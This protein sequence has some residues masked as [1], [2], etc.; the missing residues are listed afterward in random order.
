MADALLSGEELSVDNITDYMTD[1]DMRFLDSRAVLAFGDAQ[2]EIYFADHFAAASARQPD[3]YN[4]QTFANIDRLQ[5]V[6]R[7]AAGGERHG[8]VSR[9]SECLDLLGKYLSVIVVIGDRRQGRAVGCQRDCWQRRSLDQKAIGEFRGNMLGISGA[10]A[11]AEKQQ[12]V[13]CFKRR[14]D[15]LDRLFKGF[16]IIPQESSF[17]P[18]ALVEGVDDNVFHKSQSAEIIIGCVEKKEAYE[19]R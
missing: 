15:A 19:S 4:R 17:Y 7:I 2:H 6:G 1:K 10:A 16:K 13:A 8:D 9:F 18:D 12:L 14:H 11:I 3:R 5:H